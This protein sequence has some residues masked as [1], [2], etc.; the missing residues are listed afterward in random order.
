MARM[1]I[2]CHTAHEW[3]TAYLAHG[4]SRGDTCTIERH[5]RGCEDCAR[6][7]RELK[8]MFHYLTV[9][10]DSSAEEEVLSDA[11]M[12]NLLQAADIQAPAPRSSR[13]VFRNV[14]VWGSMAA[15][16]LL[17]SYLGMQS[18]QEKI[19]REHITIEISHTTLNL[20]SVPETQIV[21]TADTSGSDLNDDPLPEYGLGNHIQTQE[22][23]TINLMQPYFGLPGP[24][25]QHLYS[26]GYA[27]DLHQ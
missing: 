8:P 24:R 21:P 22:P 19:Q 25:P 2:D 15:S 17:G 1:T 18:G 12:H 26:P 20:A 16:I 4:L 14:A 5:L 7:Y 3:M 10:M 23:S 6:D 9:S 11:R 27:M 13:R